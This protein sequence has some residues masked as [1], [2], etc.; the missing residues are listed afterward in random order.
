MYNI[1]IL[2]S[3]HAPSLLVGS[4]PG[5]LNNP[6]IYF[7]LTGCIDYRYVLPPLR[8]VR[9]ISFSEVGINK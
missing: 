6:G 4:L 8:Q 5:S 7:M 9:C 3:L 1:M 2:I